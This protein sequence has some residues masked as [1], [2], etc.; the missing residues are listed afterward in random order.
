M[1]DPVP[2]VRLL[3]V[4]GED[5]VGTM[6]RAEDV[7]TGEPLAVR[8][9]HGHLCGEEGARLVFAEEARRIATLA[10]PFL[11]RVRRH[12][13]RAPVPY[14]VTDPLHGGTL[15]A[16]VAAARATEAEA[17]ALVLLALDAFRLLDGRRQFHVAAMPSRIVRVGDG[18]RLATFRDVRAADAAPRL[19]GRHR[20]DPRW[21]APELDPDRSGVPTARSIVAW[22]VGALW[23]FLRTG[24]GPR[25]VR[26]ETAFAGSPSEAAALGRLLDPDPLRRPSG[27]DACAALVRGAAI[28]GGGTP[29]RA[30][31]VPRRRPRA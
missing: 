31:P 6:Q 26:L 24:L 4:L 14:E 1:L 5:A 25:E 23:A 3:E 9:L 18:W 29:P 15:E 22:S 21:A 12:D 8:R 19:K 17:R 10:H 7:A 27:I 28:S 2:G 16:S 11:L 30:A 13:V 20:A